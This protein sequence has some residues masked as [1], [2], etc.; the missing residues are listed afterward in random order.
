MTQARRQGEGRLFPCDWW[1]VGGAVG[2]P[3]E[4]R[5]GVLGVGAVASPGHERDQFLVGAP[6]AFCE[7]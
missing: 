1:R 2:C 3:A 4:I 6:Q 7:F 5:G